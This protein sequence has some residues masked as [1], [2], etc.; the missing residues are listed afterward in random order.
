[1]HKFYVQTENSKTIKIVSYLTAIS[2]ILTDSNN[3]KVD[4]I[5]DELFKM[6]G[7]LNDQ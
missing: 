4:E 3:V 2:S 6:I 5:S 7:F 1:M